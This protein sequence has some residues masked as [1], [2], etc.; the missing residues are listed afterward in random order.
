MSFRRLFG[1]N[2]ETCGAF[3]YIN[4]EECLLMDTF[5]KKVKECIDV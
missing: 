4:R 5:G 2:F 3:E 1:M